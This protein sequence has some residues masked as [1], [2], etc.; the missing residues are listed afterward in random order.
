MVL[1]LL[2]RV[3]MDIQLMHLGIIFLGVLME[4]LMGVV[5]ISAEGL[6]EVLQQRIIILV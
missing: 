1:H 5:I 6:W 4:Y 2:K 3:L